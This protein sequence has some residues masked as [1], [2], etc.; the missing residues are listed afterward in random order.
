[1][2]IELDQQRLHGR[3]QIN[4]ARQG[5][6][7]QMGVQGQ[8][9][10]QSRAF[11]QQRVAAG[12]VNGSATHAKLL[13]LM[14]VSSRVRRTAAAVVTAPGLSPWTQMLA[15]WTVISLPSRAISLPSLASRIMLRVMMARSLRIASGSWR[16]TSVPSAL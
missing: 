13:I 3:Y 2:R 1:M 6:I 11:D 14:P 16:E 8:H 10:G 7:A 4:L 12:P 5:L 15:A 9:V